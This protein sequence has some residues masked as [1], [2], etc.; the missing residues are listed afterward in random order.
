MQITGDGCQLLAHVNLAGHTTIGP[1]TVIHPFASLGGPP[2]AKSYRGEPT[3]LEIGADCV[4][5]EYVSMNL[6]T[7]KDR[8]MTTVGDRGFFMA[9]SHVGHDCVIGNDVTMA[10]S[11]AIGGH[12]RIGDSVFIG[13]LSAVHQ[14]TRI[15][16]GAMIAGVTGVRSDVIPFSFAVGSLAI[17]AGLNVV[18]LK[19]RNF[20][21][22]TMHTI[23]AAYKR[24]FAHDGSTLAERIDGIEAEFGTSEPVMKIVTFV[25]EARDRALCVP[26]HHR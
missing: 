26:G 9:N 21:R 20:S 16:E 8:G 5:R 19:R 25:R 7:A 17:L 23:R 11:A 13:G 18:G 6:G 24:L 10:N 22:E 3:G 4:I 15:G 2:Q 12:S 14:F 1:R